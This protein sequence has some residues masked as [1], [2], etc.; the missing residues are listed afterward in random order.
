MKR[1]LTTTTAL[2]L[3]TACSSTPAVIPTRNLESPS[4]MTFVCLKTDGDTLSGKAMS[5]C[6]GRNIFEPS[7]TVNGQRVLGT[8]AFITSPGRNE[9]AVADMDRGRLLDLAPLTPGYGMLPSGNDPEVIAASPDG[10]WVVTANRASCDF[11]MV[12]PARLLAGAFTAGATVFSPV[13]GAGDVSRRITVRTASGVLAASIGEMAFL[14]PATAATTCADPTVKP[15][16]VATFPGC[17]MVALLDFSFADASATIVDAYYVR[18]TGLLP[19]G[20]DPVCPTECD[21][22]GVDAGGPSE[23]GAAMGIATID[24]GVAAAVDGG[25]N[26]SYL[27]ALALIPDGSRVY[28]GSSTGDSVAS[29]DV[30]S[31]GFG[32]PSRVTL[33]ENPGGI[34]RLRLNVDPYATVGTVEGKFLDDRGKFLYAFTND[35]SVRVINIDSQPVE[36]DVNLLLDSAD[37]QPCHPIGEAGFRRRPLAQGPGLR[38]PTLTNPDSTPPVPRDITFAEIRP[39]PPT[40]TYYQSLS[41]QFGF[42]LASS[43]QVYV[44]NLAPQPARS[45]TTASEDTTP[46]SMATHS[47]REY[48]DS[49]KSGATAI[50]L[51]VAPQR[52]VVDSDQAFA[53]TAT[54]SALDG[55]LIQP[56]SIDT[57]KRYFDFPDSNAVVSNSWSV[58]WEGLLPRT[59]RKTGLVTGKSDLLAG[60]LNDEG[61]DFCASG[62]QVG[63]VLMFSGCTQD[64][65]CQPDDQFTCQVTVS[66]GPR[67]CLPRDSTASA[68]VVSKE[69]CA[70]FLGSRVRYEVAAVTATSLQLRLKLDEV[71]K[72]TLN[73]CQQA[74][75]ATDCQTDVDH[76]K[77]A[78]DSPDGGI[79]KKFECLAVRDGEN[80][81]CV[82]RCAHD[83]DCRAGNVCEKVDGSLV[84]DL[85]VE[86]PPMDAYCFPQSMIAGSLQPTIAYSVRAGHAFTVSGSLMPNVSPFKRT[87][88]GSCEAQP[89]ADP[90]LV[91]RI[92]LSAPRCPDAFIAQASPASGLYVEQLNAQA[93][94]NPCLYSGVDGSVDG[95]T[96]TANNPNV[97]ANVRAFFQNPQIRFVLSNLNQYAGDLLSIQF[98]LQSGYG[99]SPLTAY[100]SP[101]EV[102]LTMGTRIIA[103]PTQTPESPLWSNSAELISYPYIYVVDQGKTALTAGSHGQILRV[104]PRSGSTQIISFDNTLSGSTPF[105]IQ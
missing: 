19:A 83:S 59:S 54:Y 23:A 29:F 79:S 97:A 78:V 56:F 4:D 8:F 1:L 91:A 65:D 60:V 75:E 47:F 40:D 50:E 87:A 66:G 94:S 2:F 89:L 9:I 21:L 105:Q 76:G 86:A 90:S 84:G 101:S 37:Q 92:P 13:T 69:T 25:A 71:P 88:S 32:N 53:T 30:S 11:T 82:K 5:E 39:V 104:N 34:R 3:L 102:L 74:T 42:L 51:S 57:S 10:C 49:G 6:H 38:I 7:A 99:Y 22:G 62:V 20:G 67:L 15:Q 17:D 27:Q 24:G 14:P 103:G 77:G 45:D 85:C 80:R 33:A 18:S 52:A 46:P 35:D 96:A 31:T 98:Q 44:V 58:T 64:S 73:P 61:A 26:T 12:D 41:G 63:D 81:R 72:T 95:A 55:P 28:V 93:G 68:N 100:A 70:K 36:C 16:A 43:G 48:R